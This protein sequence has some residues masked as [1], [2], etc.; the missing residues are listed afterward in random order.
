MSKGF[1]I[2]TENRSQLYLI[3]MVYI[4]INAALSLFLAF[5]SY[6]ASLDR[7]GI[8][9]G[10]LSFVVLYAELDR[11]FVINKR[12]EWH[13]ILVLSV[14]IKSIT[15][16]VPV[17]ELGAGVCATYLVDA[18]IG[19]VPFVSVYLQTLIDGA[20]L[21]IFVAFISFPTHFICTALKNRPNLGKSI[22]AG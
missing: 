16:L 15:Q 19:R 20:I 5:N 7:Y 1:I 8:V 21:S 3:W 12:I 11:H 2:T 4:S 18:A 14:I 9:V 10:V 13:K 22:I 17:I 6:K